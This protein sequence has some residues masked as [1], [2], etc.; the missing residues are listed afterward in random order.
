MRYRG[1]II[2]VLFV[3]AILLFIR[4]TV[5]SHFGQVPHSIPLPAILILILAWY[6]GKQYDKYVNISTIDPLTGAYNR[7]YVMNKFP[8]IVSYANKR[9]LNISVIM[10]DIN[11]F[12]EINDTYGHAIG[13]NVLEDVS[14]RLRDSFEK[15]DTVARWGGDEFLI[16]TFFSDEH[17]M[18][19]KIN[20]FKSRLNSHH[21]DNLSVSIGKS[22]YPSD[23]TCLKALVTIADTNMYDTKFRLKNST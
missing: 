11:E 19:K 12:K 6:L 3:S 21:I 1:R 22:T 18:F 2:S 20:D 4:K 14:K 5:E 15:K 8:K 10:V 23:A 9:K 7:R 16:L 17:V 13:D